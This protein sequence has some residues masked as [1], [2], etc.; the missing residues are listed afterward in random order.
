M[1][2]G[3]ILTSIS[4]A[5]LLASTAP[6]SVAPS[7]LP[8]GAIRCSPGPGI[9]DSEAAACNWL[10]AQ[11]ETSSAG[12]VKKMDMYRKYVSTF[13]MYGLQNLVSPTCF[14]NCIRWVVSLSLTV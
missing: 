12:S 3:I 13:G 2:D 4:G 1:R 8:A 5:P 11:Y 7:P 9:V 14:T 10:Q 6:A